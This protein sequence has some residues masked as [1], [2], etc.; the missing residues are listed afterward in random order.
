[1]YPYHL[2]WYV[3]INAKWYVS[4]K[5]IRIHELTHCA[6]FSALYQEQQN[7]RFFCRTTENIRLAKKVPI[8]IFVSDFLRTFFPISPWVLRWMA[9]KIGEWKK[10]CHFTYHHHSRL[11]HKKCDSG[12][13]WWGTKMENVWMSEYL[14]LQCNQSLSQFTVRIFVCL[15]S[16]MTKK[17]R[18]VVEI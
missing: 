12:N 14:K 2:F 5:M 13:N 9:N 8:F 11:N 1:M 15:M 3:L 17:Y 7:K 10:G 6:T 18:A 16:L 4:E